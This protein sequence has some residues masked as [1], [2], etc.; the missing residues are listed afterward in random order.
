MKTGIAATFYA[1]YSATVNRLLA[2]IDSFKKLDKS[3]TAVALSGLITDG[4][5]FGVSAVAN[6]EL[7]PF[8]TDLKTITTTVITSMN[9][10][11]Q[12]DKYY[13]TLGLS[14]VIADA[15]EFGDGNTGADL[16]SCLSSMEALE[17]ELVASFHY[18]NLCRME[19]TASKHAA[20][21]DAGITGAQVKS[22]ITSLGAID[23]FL[24]AGFHYTNLNKLV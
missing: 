7:L 15:Y 5:D 9:E 23:T 19:Y 1:D 14:G 13:A 22:V 10:H 12:L 21:W 11:V 16:K 18:T 8:F 2:A 20:T 24:T 17:T 6:E 3:Y 4:S